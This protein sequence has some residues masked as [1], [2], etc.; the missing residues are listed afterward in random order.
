[1]SVISSDGLSLQVGD[2]GASEVFL[3]VKGVT[4]TRFE[5]M[6]QAHHAH[7]IGM[8]AW[9]SRIGSSTREVQMDFDALATDDA[10]T[11]RLRSLSL[12]GEA[13]NF[14]LKISPTET[15]NFTGFITLYRET[16]AAGDIKKLR[17][18]LVS[19]GA[20]TIS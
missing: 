20:L 13:G 4:L 12:S 9:V 14:R 19:T 5:L 8:D 16:I 6:Q 3:P 7:V 15:W 10:A 1:M 18:Q 17:C 11:I 2:G